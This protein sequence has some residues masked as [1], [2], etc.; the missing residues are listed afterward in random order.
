M[1]YDKVSL[2]NQEN[3]MKF[4]AAKEELALEKVRYA[5]LEKKFKSLYVSSLN[6]PQANKAVNKK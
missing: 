6:M 4:S 5:Q 2:E 3:Y 1:T